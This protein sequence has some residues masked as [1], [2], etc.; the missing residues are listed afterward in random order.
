VRHVSRGNSLDE[1]PAVLVFTLKV[2]L[3]AGYT[4]N[5]IAPLDRGSE[6]KRILQVPL[7]D[8][9][10]SPAQSDGSLGDWIT[11]K[12]ADSELRVRQQM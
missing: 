11:S 1:V 7:D 4:E 8:L 9:G 3:E 10:T 2:L 5:G 12:T 6:G